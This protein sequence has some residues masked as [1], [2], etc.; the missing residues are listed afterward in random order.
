MYTINLERSSIRKKQAQIQATLGELK[1]YPTIALLELTSLPDALFQA[2]RKKIREKGGKVKVLR[3]A[4]LM[5]VLQKAGKLSSYAEKVDRPFALIL[6]SLSPYE[7][8][9]FFKE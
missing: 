9:K 2:L 5:R 3:K 7:L 6:S 4:V 1:N 8:N